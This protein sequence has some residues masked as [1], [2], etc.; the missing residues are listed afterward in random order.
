VDTI[1][2]AV[3]GRGGIIVASTTSGEDQHAHGGEHADTQRD[4]WAQAL[5]FCHMTSFG[6]M[7][8]A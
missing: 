3:A 4:R 8:R 5:T 6:G 2:T 1:G 7:C